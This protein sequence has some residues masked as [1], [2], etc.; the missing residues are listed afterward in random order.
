MAT[1]IQDN[2]SDIGL[3]VDIVTL[4]GNIIKQKVDRNEFEAI[5]F[6]FPNKENAVYRIRNYFDDN[7]IIGYKN[8]AID[9]LL[10]LIENTGDKKEIDRL[11]S[12]LR[13]IFQKDLPFTLLVPQVQTHI[14][15]SDIKGLSNLFKADPVWFLESLWIE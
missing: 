1:Y 14:V 6:R 9:S 2:L 5:L 11:F 15:R 12:Q 7:S 3:N 13:P 10:T 8:K 4:E